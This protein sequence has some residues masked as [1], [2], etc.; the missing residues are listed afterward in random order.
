M[1]APTLAGRYLS[2]WKFNVDNGK[3]LGVGW[4]GQAPVYVDFYVSGQPS[5]ITRIN[6]APG[7]TSATVNGISQN[8]QPVRFIAGAR[9]YQTMSVRILGIVATPASLSIQ[10]AD[11]QVLL[12]VGS[13]RTDFTVILPGTQDYIITVTPTTNQDINFA[14]QVAIQ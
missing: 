7:T 6:F 13:G 3:A 12:P 9:A 5:N 14:L 1:G 2:E 4:A 10:G 8:R 11:G